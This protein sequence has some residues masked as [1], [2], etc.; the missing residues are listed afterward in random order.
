MPVYQSI[1][2]AW[3]NRGT[4]MPG[5]EDWIPKMHLEHLKHRAMRLNRL[6]PMIMH[7]V[8]EKSHDHSEAVNLGSNPYQNMSSSASAGTH[9]TT[10]C[11][12]PAATAGIP[13]AIPTPITILRQHLY[14]DP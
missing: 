10:G 11:I 3:F 1:R 4:R 13:T 7:W 5:A 8:E 9:T 12:Y 6:Y 2:I 14:G